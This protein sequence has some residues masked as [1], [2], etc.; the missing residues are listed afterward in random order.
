[1]N[2]TSGYAGQK[3]H[4]RPNPYFLLGFVGGLLFYSKWSLDL[5]SLNMDSNGS[6]GRAMNG[7]SACESL[8]S[9]YYELDLHW[10]YQ[11]DI[12]CVIGAIDRESRGKAV[13]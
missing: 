12:P 1:M 9:L 11:I 8:H 3:A 13:Q 7:S 10:I 2:F 6:P 4:L 5:A